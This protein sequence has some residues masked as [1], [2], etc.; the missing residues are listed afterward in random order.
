MHIDDLH[1]RQMGADEEIANAGDERYV[2]VY[3]IEKNI[4]MNYRDQKGFGKSAN[5]VF[6]CTCYRAP[7]Q[8]QFQRQ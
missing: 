6:D 4:L 1:L 5:G 8:A 3:D 7:A 2:G